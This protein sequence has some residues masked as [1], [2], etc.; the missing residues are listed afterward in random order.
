MKLTYTTIALLTAAALFSSCEKET[1]VS[2]DAPAETSSAVS[3]DTYP[4]KTC[5]VSGEELGSMGEP[6]IVEHG[7][8]TVKLCCKSCIE[9]FNKD[10]GKY[11]AMVKQAKAD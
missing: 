8:T 5:P 1:K 10:P 6:V 4:M 7:G 2:T 11:T 9:D 3:T